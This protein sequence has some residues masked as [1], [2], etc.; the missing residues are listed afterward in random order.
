MLP[1]RLACLTLVLAAC[2]FGDNRSLETTHTRHLCGDAIR[3]DD[4]GCDDGNT[5][6]GD[7][8][9]EVCA[10]ETTA[11]A[12]GNGIREV[13]EACD[14]GNTAAGDGCSATCSAESVC[15]NG[16]REGSE[17][18]DDGNTT[19]GDGC[20]PSCQTE[21]ATACMLVPQA[22]CA[23]GQACDLEDDGDTSCRAVTAQGNSNSHCAV[24]TACRAGYTCTDDGDPAN[25]SW[26]ARF[27]ITDANC[28]GTGSRCVFA[29][30][31]SG[32][33][34]L[35]VD[36]CSNACDPYAQ[37]GCPSQMGCI[38]RDATA[39]DYT[40][41]RY[42]GATPDGSSCTATADCQPGSDC[43][44]AGGVKTCE[45]YCIVGNN[46]TCPQFQTCHAFT[47]DIVI[48]TTH[49]GSCN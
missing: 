28:T 25:A 41:C 20:S 44:S 46:A 42:L 48:G 7:G 5:T 40:D 4:E 34:P 9:S 23:A 17:A 27:C 13:G 38:A 43:V 8:C 31:S 2:G 45:S 19:S 1:K 26:C 24:D 29:L 32:G 22:G 39:G 49:Y 37:T 21:T 11:P 30:S 16:T 10:V 33:A 36:V 3:D 47:H 6:S 18:C 15:G 14:D 35:G 12:C